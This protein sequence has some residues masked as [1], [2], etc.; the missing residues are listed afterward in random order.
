[1]LNTLH[2]TCNKD[3]KIKKDKSL[4]S[5]FTFRSDNFS[6]NP[7]NHNRKAEKERKKKYENKF[8]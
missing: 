6:N 1:M 7:S 2:I 8:S 5:L 4:M 3:I